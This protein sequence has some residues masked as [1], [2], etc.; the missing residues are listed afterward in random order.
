MRRGDVDEVHAGLD[1]RE[2]L[3]V[4]EVLGPRRGRRGQHDVIGPVDERAD[5]A[6]ELDARERTRRIRAAHGAHAHAECERPL[7]DRPPIPPR[8]TMPTV[9]PATE[10]SGGIGK[11]QY[12]GG[13]CTN[14]S[15]NRLA[16]A[17][18]AAMT[19]SAIGIAAAPRA[20]HDAAVVDR[21]GHLVDA[22]SRELHPAHAGSVEPAEDLVPAHV[23]TEEDVGLQPV[24]RIPG[25]VDQLDLRMRGED[26]RAMRIGRA[27]LGD[28]TRAHAQKIVIRPPER[29]RTLTRVSRLKD[30]CIDC[31][32]PWSLSH[33][34]A[35]VL[36]YRV[37]PHTDA[38]LADLRRA[39][40]RR[41]RGG[42]FDRGRSR[43]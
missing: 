26:Q 31:T 15:G 32:D 27:E 19:H 21:I 29:R 13:S 40:V 1:R 41:R 33:W 6:D 7:G 23:A 3:G 39:R 22:G 18:I 9:L 11:F 24:R 28:D 38:D 43:R 12:F 34:W 37:R 10:S 20:R 16:R 35:P 36:G 42:S 5:V 25:K 4:D 8:P 17:R 2:H 30:V 14:T